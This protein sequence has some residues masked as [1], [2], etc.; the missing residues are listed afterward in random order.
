M[1]PGLGMYT[2]LTGSAL[3]GSAESLHPVDQLYLGLR[4]QHD[5]A[6]HACG[7]TTGVALGHPPHAHQRVRARPE[8]QL[9]QPADPCKVPRLR[10]REDPLP[11]P[12]YVPLGPPPVDLAPVERRVLWSTHHDHGRRRLACPR[13]P[14][15]S[16][17]F[18][19]QA[20]LTASARF[21]GRAP[22]PVSGRLSTTTSW[23]TGRSRRG[24][25]LP[26]GHR[27]SLLGHPFP[28]EEFGPPHGRPTGPTRS[29]PRRG[30]RVPHARAATGVGALCTPGTTVLIPDRGHFPAGA[31]R[32]AAASP[33]TP[34]HHPT[35][36]DLA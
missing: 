28:A 8:H 2:R 24:F 10:C 6:V 23:R 34:P 35:D 4:G 36:G 11:Q 29:G 22:G 31:C 5:L 32:F 20:H 15:S 9:L 19:S 12:P 3:N 13:V 33:C 25:P 18:S 7:Q 26:F 14:G 27:H 17:S 21:R 1:P 30:Y 16:S